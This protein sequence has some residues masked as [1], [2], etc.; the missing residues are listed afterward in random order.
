MN[1]RIVPIDKKQI[2][3]FEYIAKWCN[4]PEIKYLIG[5]NF[6]E[7]EMPD[8]K[9][10]EIQKNAHN[11]PKKYLYL[12]LDGDEPIGDVSIMIDPK[13]LH[14]K[15]E[16]TGWISICIGE[17][18]YRGKGVAHE[19]MLFLEKECKS[20]GLKRIE[21][22]VFEYNERAI[23]FYKKL[24]Y[25]VFD[26]IEDFVYYEGKWRADIRMEKYL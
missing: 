26:R 19:A 12:I 5:A 15:E 13:H 24:G 25:E 23:A 9:S 17:K 18:D 21:L 2:K 11:N 20:L 14:K 4:D 22:G 8:V 16:G 6:S 3:P 1:L 10:E 7:A